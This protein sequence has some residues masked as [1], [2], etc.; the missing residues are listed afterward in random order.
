MP[1]L[2]AIA[3]IAPIAIATAAT[4]FAEPESAQALCLRSNDPVEQARSLTLALRAELRPSLEVAPHSAA[5]ALRL[6]F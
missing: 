2:S 3:P 6:P 1:R 4:A 5:R